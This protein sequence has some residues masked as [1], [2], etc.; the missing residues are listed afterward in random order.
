M[1][2]LS[3]RCTTVQSA[4]HPLHAVKLA[5]CWRMPCSLLFFAACAVQFDICCRMPHSLLFVA[6]CLYSFYLLPYV[7]QFAFC[8]STLHNLL[9]AAACHT[10]I[11][12]LIFIAVCRT[13]CY[14]LLHTA[15]FPIYFL[16]TV[17]SA[18][19]CSELYS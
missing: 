5:I 16:H 11:Y 13:V 8:C 12:S 4:I 3:L 15:Q 7:V 9:F 14:L 17:Q 2:A 10:V 18:I 19:C 6:K 1:Y